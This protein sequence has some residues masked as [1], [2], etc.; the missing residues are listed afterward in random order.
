M[1]KFYYLNR[2]IIVCKDS[3]NFQIKIKLIV[4]HSNIQ[5]Y[6]YFLQFSAVYSEIVVYF[7]INCP[8]FLEKFDINNGINLTVDIIS[9]DID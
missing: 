1:K 6:Q 3:D 9:I 7:Q 4:F 2:N 8:R 5:Y